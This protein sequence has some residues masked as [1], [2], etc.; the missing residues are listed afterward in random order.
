MTVIELIRE[1]IKFNPSATIKFQTIPVTEFE[2]DDIRIDNN[3]ATVPEHR[4]ISEY[5]N[6][7]WYGGSEQK[8]DEIIIN[9]KSYQ[10]GVDNEND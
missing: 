4:I 6:I 9:L 7:V 10:G 3:I 1:L 5:Q 2:V 8:T